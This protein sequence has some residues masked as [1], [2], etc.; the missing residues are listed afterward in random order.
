V[1]DGR[2]E[3]R[4]IT[5]PI[6]CGND[7]CDVCRWLNI[8]ITWAIE[9][10][11][12]DDSSWKHYSYPC[13]PTEAFL[14]ATTS[15]ERDQQMNRSIVEWRLVKTTREVVRTKRRD[16]EEGDA[17]GRNDQTGGSGSG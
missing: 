12:D 8:E 15:P 3:R 5:I 9:Y 14:A 6:V 7:T 17:G 11:T 16:S 13:A 4:E 10:R 2:V 1:S